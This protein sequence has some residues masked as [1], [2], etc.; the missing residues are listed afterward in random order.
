MQRRDLERE[1]QCGANEE[2]PG[3]GVAREQTG[4]G[5]RRERDRSEQ[6]GIVGKSMAVIGI[7]PRPVE[8]ILAVGVRLEVEGHST[9]ERCALPQGQIAR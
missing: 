7:G 2:R 5:D 3:L 1:S 4:A 8:D 9:D 6:L